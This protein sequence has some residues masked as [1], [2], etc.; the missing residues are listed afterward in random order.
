M[1]YII[2]NAHVPVGT[3]N[4]YSDK[5]VVI[6]IGKKRQYFGELVILISGKNTKRCS[7]LCPSY[8]TILPLILRSLPPESLSVLIPFLVTDTKG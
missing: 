7:L 3:K 5:K 2:R 8:P 1:R 4:K 6:C